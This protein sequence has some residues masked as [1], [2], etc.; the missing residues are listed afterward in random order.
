MVHLLS[1]LPLANDKF[2][3][4]ESFMSQD[5]GESDLKWGLTLICVKN[6]EAQC[7]FAHLFFNELLK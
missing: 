3:H 2:S 7:F 5:N 6:A 4:R 1:L